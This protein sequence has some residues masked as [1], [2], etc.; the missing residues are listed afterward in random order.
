M[1][2]IL[3][4]ITC[5]AVGILAAMFT[6]YT[7][8]SSLSPYFAIGILA[9]LDSIFGGIASNINNN[10]RMKIFISGFFGN[11]LLA[12]LLTH[13][14]KILNV[15]IYFAAVLVFG[16]RLFQNFAIIRRFLLSKY[17]PDNIK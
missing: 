4:I 17:F 16:T 6:P 15:D 5:V 12:A 14:G 10:F 13:I 3:V 2:I 7:I 8:P 1:I 9:G 11:A